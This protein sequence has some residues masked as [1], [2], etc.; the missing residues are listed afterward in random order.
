MENQKKLYTLVER[1]FSGNGH[2][3]ICMM[4]N[5]DSRIAESKF[6]G[7]VVKIGKGGIVDRSCALLPSGQPA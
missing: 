6:I 5:D 2:V 7:E 4:N 1:D 3:C